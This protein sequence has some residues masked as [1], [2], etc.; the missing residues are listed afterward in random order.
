[1][2][3]HDEQIHGLAIGEVAANWVSRL[4]GDV[5][6]QDMRSAQSEEL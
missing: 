4:L 3:V 1:M 5:H 2:A 6:L